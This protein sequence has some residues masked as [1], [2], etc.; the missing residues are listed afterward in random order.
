MSSLRAFSPDGQQLAEAAPDGRLQLWDTGS[1]TLRQELARSSHLALRSTCVAWHGKSAAAALVAVG[2]DGGAVLLWDAAR[3]ELAH[4]LRGHTQA[5]LDVAFDGA[6]TL[7]S[8]GAD[9]QVCCWSVSSGSL[10]HTFKAG[11]AAVHR[12]CLA[13]DGLHAALGGSAIRLVRREG[14]KRLARLPGHAEPVQCLSFS[15]DGRYLLSSSGDRHLTL[16]S[17]S[18]ASASSSDALEQSAA[19]LALEADVVSAGFRPGGGSGEGEAPSS[20]AFFA[21]TADGRL[22]VWAVPAS[23]LAPPKKAKKK[24]AAAPPSARLPPAA[25]CAVSIAPGEPGAGGEERILCAAFSGEHELLVG[26][27]SPARPHFARV[28]VALPGGEL[29][30]EVVL[31]RPS[32]GL[33]AAADGKGKRK[34][35]REEQPQQLGA[36]DMALPRAAVRHSPGPAERRPSPEPLEGSLGGM[37]PLPLAA[38]AAV[39]AAESERAAAADAER[40]CL[41]EAGSRPSFGDRLAGMGADS[42]PAMAAGGEGGGGGGG[43]GAEGRR[44]P[45]ASSQVALLVQALQNGD[46]VMLD[47]ALQVQDAHVVSATV[48]RLPVTAVLPFLQAVLHRIQGKPARV[49]TLASWLRALLSTHAAYLMSCSQASRPTP[50]LPTPPAPPTPHRP[51][52]PHA[53]A[54][55]ADAALP[56]HRRASRGLQAAAEARRPH[57]D[58]AGA[59][60][61]AGGRQPAGRRA[62]VGPA[63]HVR[64][65]G[66]GA[67]RGGGGGGGRGGV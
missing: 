14:W 30:P 47:Q 60:R 65:G 58:A 23:T 37:P 63:A 50:P 11:K 16:W 27:G 10:V 7:Y 43:G 26:Y 39:A 64:R 46:S 5:V 57:A 54:P 31:P 52:A 51:T 66:G 25:G 12:L 18:Y 35:G 45:T 34:R 22:G 6:D 56:A 53:A 44:K 32:E 62:V 2:T 38:A 24:K 42:R 29:K 8:S 20:Y 59:D 40:A 36:M 28:S 3:G 15:P 55:L 1:S 21:L 49:A 61:V 67:R 9:K 48:A 13:P 33:L 19:S 4:E 17:V 41:S